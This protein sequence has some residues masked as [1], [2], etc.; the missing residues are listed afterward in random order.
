[1]AAKLLPRPPLPQKPLH[2]F[3]YFTSEPQGHFTPLLLGAGLSLHWNRKGFSVL[4]SFDRSE[5]SDIFAHTLFNNT[6]SSLGVCPA[7]VIPRTCCFSPSSCFICPP[8]SNVD[9][10]VPI[11]LL[12]LFVY[13]HLEKSHFTVMASIA[14]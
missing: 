10:R 5:T 4:T 13:F 3:S 12:C 1:M 14:S 8:P 11:S 9:L 6:P 7:H 2:L